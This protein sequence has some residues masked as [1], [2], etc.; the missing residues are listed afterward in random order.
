M[1]LASVKR[2]RP[3]VPGIALAVACILVVDLFVSPHLSFNHTDSIPRGFYWRTAVPPAGAR[4]GDIVIAW[5][6]TAYSHFGHD[7][8]FLDDGNCD[9]ATTLIKSVVAIAG[10]RVHLD[11][12]GVVVNGRPIPNSVPLP[13]D[14]YGT[15]MPHVRYGDYLMKPN[16][17]WIASA[18]TKGFDSRYFGPIARNIAIA[19]PLL[20]F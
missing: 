12:H 9:G 18:R 17:L 13:V 19:H 15:V 3:I 10:D 6:P 4:R 16:K 11:A 1:S 8:G 7:R 14:G 20:V 5:A 2:R